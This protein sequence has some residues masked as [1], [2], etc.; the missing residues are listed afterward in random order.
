MTGIDT[1]VLVALA[2]HSHPH[3]QRAVAAAEKQLAAA[4]GPFVI[5]PVVVAE[6]LHAVTD[7]K[8]VQPALTM[9]A[10]RAWLE[11]WGRAV[12]VQWCHPDTP[13]CELWLR[14]LAEFHLGR[15]RIL[16]NL[17]AA[18]LHREGVSRLLTS[19]PD[20]FRVFGVFELIVP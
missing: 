4:G 8:R 16:D 9:R 18:T 15:K 1:N 11:E 14:W 3:H 10:A 19:N 7:P 13:A 5:S 2:V 6:F 12:G 17:L 20:D